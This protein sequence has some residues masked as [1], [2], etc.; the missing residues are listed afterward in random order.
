M[1]T[2]NHKSFCYLRKNLFS[3][4]VI[5]PNNS[6]VRSRISRPLDA[7]RRHVVL[8]CRRTTSVSNFP[9][10]LPS[11]SQ[12]NRNAQAP[13]SEDI[14]NLADDESSDNDIEILPDSQPNQQQP[15]NVITQ[16]N[17]HNEPNNG[18]HRNHRGEFYDRND[19]FCKTISIRVTVSST[20][21]CS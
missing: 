15:A 4:M 19:E 18:I 1:A 9:A 2:V 10:I 7:E 6:H 13:N 3:D 21:D 14:I 16:A 17:T 8:P 20:Y 5:H 11:T 12:N